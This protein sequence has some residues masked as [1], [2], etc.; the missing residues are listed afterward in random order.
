[1]AD[2][3]LRPMQ[4]EEVEEL[5]RITGA[6]GFFR[7]EELEVAREVLA[8]HA[9]KGDAS[10]YRV[11]VAANGS[12]L[13]GYVCF[14]P[15]PLTHG[16][17]DVYWIAIDPKFQRHGLG[18]RLMHR[19]EQEVIQERGRLIVVETS[20]QELYE[21]TRRFYR[22]LGYSEVSRIPDFYAAGD[23]KLTFA[24]PLHQGGNRPMAP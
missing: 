6:T 23:A 19:A 5:V 20:S 3:A 18:S 10:G 17:W 1:M 13:L 14:G 22:G 24:K 7:Q 4:H 12:R 9:S 11:K 21:P 16:T 15:A 2:I 8:E